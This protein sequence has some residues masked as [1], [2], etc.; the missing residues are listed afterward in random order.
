MSFWQGLK[1]L[2]FGKRKEDARNAPKHLKVTYKPK[3]V[4]APVRNKRGRG[5][6]RRAT[7]QWCPGSIIPPSERKTA[8]KEE[9]EKHMYPWYKRQLIRAGLRER[10]SPPK[11]EL[12]M[13][14]AQRQAVIRR[15]FVGP[16]KPEELQGVIEL[17]GVPPMPHGAGR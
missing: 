13:T 10:F 14:P 3:P 16:P 7:R 9:L 17:D 11:P 12:I 5:W 6:K 15:A 8:S 2:F 1:N 4:A